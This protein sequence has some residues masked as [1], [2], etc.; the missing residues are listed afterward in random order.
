MLLTT[1]TKLAQR[2]LRGDSEA[3]ARI[4]EASFPCVWSF[5]A[6]RLGSPAAAEALTD[7][8]LS[9]V[10]REL[11]R[12]DGEV[13]FAAWLLAVCKETAHRRPYPVRRGPQ[14]GEGGA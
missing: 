8:I 11:D 5:A 6:R 2:A 14:A 12:Y 9:R 4:Y 3:F 7:R 10:F 13:P 1:D